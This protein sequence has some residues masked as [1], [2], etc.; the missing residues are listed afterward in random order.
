MEAAIHQGVA[1]I[2]LM[3]LS[4]LIAPRIQLADTELLFCSASMEGEH[5]V[6]TTLLDKLLSL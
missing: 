6:R 3:E 5:E 4:K 1:E 2:W